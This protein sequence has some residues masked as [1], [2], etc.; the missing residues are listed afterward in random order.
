MKRKERKKAE[1]DASSLLFSVF[2]YHQQGLNPASA[3]LP[4]DTFIILKNLFRTRA[5]QLRVQG[6]EG[7]KSR[8]SPSL[9]SL[10]LQPTCRMI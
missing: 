10:V 8:P 1:N 2:P 7:I 6:T 9:S 5:S 4:V 3:L